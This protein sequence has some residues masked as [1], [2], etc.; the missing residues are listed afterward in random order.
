MKHAHCTVQEAA[1]KLVHETLE[2]NDGGLIAVDAEGNVA[3]PF[4]TLQ[5]WRG[6]ADSDGRYE[7]MLD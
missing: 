3:M 1:D 7:V 2:E 5:M 6:V 4:N